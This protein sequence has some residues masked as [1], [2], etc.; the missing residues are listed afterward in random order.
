MGKVENYKKIVA[1]IIDAFDFKNKEDETIYI[2]DMERG[3]FVIFRDGWL[4]NSKRSYGFYVHIDIRKD[5]KIWVR[6]DATTDPP[7]TQKLLDKGIPKSDIV[8]AFHPPI[9]RPDTGFAVA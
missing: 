1:E 5:G 7:V 6:Y 4:N 3:H 2:K 9:V 8:L